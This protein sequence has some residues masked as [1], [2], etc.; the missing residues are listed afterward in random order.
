MSTDEK[1]NDE[2]GND[3]AEQI[4]THRPALTLTQAAS[5]CGVSRSTIRRKLDKGMFDGAYRLAGPNGPD[6]GEWVIPIEALI[7][8][9]LKPNGVRSA[10][11]LPLL[12]A[13]DIPNLK[14]IMANLAQSQNDVHD[15]D[16]DSLDLD[17]R[18]R[19][20][21]VE[22]ERDKWHA[23]ADERGRMLTTMD[24]VIKALPSGSEGRHQNA[25]GSPN[26]LF[27]CLAI[28]GACLGTVALVVAIVV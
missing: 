5:A 15:T 20:A 17:L 1:F 8:A 10:P 23:I 11:S 22:G 28:L 25:T 14:Q 18:L 7:Q 4:Q 19:V 16:R 27:L 13:P 21:E 24:V 9:G 12:Q 6:T 2:Q 26:K 3:T